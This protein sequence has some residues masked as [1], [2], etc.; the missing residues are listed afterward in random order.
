MTHR[1]V[2]QFSWQHGEVID[3]VVMMI[4]DG[5]FLIEI[6]SHWGSIPF[7]KILRLEEKLW[8]EFRPSILVGKVVSTSTVVLNKFSVRFM[9]GSVFEFGVM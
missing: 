8:R 4:R 3:Q 7:V 6:Q 9:D 5:K 2:S 1:Q